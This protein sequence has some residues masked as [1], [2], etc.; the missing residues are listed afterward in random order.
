MA[1]KLRMSLKSVFNLVPLLFALILLAAILF[2]ALLITL[3]FMQIGIPLK[4]LLISGIV[5]WIVLALTALPQV[6]RDP[7]ETGTRRIWLIVIFALPLAGSAA[8]FIKKYRDL[9]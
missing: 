5:F 3:T 6:L 4:P 8:W 2:P 1:G 7:L 9:P